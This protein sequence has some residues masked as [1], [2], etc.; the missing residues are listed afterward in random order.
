MTENAD[1]PRDQLVVTKIRVDSSSANAHVVWNSQLMP[2]RAEIVSKEVLAISDHE[3]G[4]SNMALLWVT[5]NGMGVQ[6]LAI[7]LELKLLTPIPVE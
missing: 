4:Q 2:Q 6:K 7:P 3:H 5:A 1:D